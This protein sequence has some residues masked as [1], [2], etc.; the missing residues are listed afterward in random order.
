M[1]WASSRCLHVGLRQFDLT[2][3]SLSSQTVHASQ[4]T[5]GGPVV[6]LERDEM[7]SSR[8]VSPAR[9]AGQ[10]GQRTCHA[11]RHVLS[12]LLTIDP[13]VLQHLNESLRVFTARCRAG[14]FV[15]FTIQT[16]QNEIPSTPRGHAPSTAPGCVLP[17]QSTA[18]NFITATISTCTFPG[19][20]DDDPLWSTC[21]MRIDSAQWTAY[22]PT[23][24]V[25]LRNRPFH[26][27]T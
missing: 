9:H 14:F 10:L 16:V 15:K 2:L 11:P 17:S 1:S 5:N 8:S 3:V 24:T 13:C 19:E 7:A 18:C 21:S 12:G 4:T 6:L 22:R 20:C 23:L 27:R 25:E 26:G